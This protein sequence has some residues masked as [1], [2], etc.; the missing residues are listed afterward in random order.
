AKD[1]DGFHVQNMGALAVGE[2]G[3]VPCTPLGSLMLLQDALPELSG[4]YAVIVGRSNIV[5]KP[6][7]LLLLQQHCTVT[8]VHSRTVAIEEHC[9]RADI[10]VAAVGIARFIKAD[11]VKP[12]AVVIDVG[13]NRI[14]E[15]GKSRLVGDVDFDAVRPKTSAITPVPGGV[16]PMTI[17]C[18]MHNTISAARAQHKHG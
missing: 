7:A 2:P 17:A 18:L 13:I 6:M 9:R 14:H 4:K 16:G 15:D 11:W 1:V 5:G 8:I 3:M 12:G 10:L